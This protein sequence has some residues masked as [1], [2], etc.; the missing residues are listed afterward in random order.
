[1]VEMLGMEVDMKAGIIKA[2]RGRVEKLQA[3]LGK[4]MQTH[5]PTA[6]QLAKLSGY[7]L[8]MSLALGPISRLRTRSFYAMILS[9]DSWSSKMAWSPSAVEDLHFWFSS[10]EHCHGQPFWKKDPRVSVLSWSDASDSGWGGFSVTTKGT[11]LAKG[12]WPVEVREHGWS[13][14]WRE[15]RA[16]SLVVS[17]LS[18]ELE[19]SV[20]LHRSDNQAAVR[21]IQVGSAKPHL[22][23]VA[24][25][26]H[27]VCGEHGIRL[28]A[29]WVPRTQNELADYLSKLVDVDDWQVHPRLF[30]ELDDVWGPHTLD[31]FASLRTK[32]IE[33]F[34]S[35]WWNPGCAGI[36]AFTMDWSCERVWLVPPLYLIG[37]V[38][39]MLVISKCHGT[40]VVPEWPSA[41]W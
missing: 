36:D 5:Y 19:G 11:E 35:R 27:K 4:M 41:P 13:S 40:L 20:C 26:I 30:E 2:S 14:T 39:D 32:Q 23:Q 7:L 22:Q 28:I 24:L 37:Q 18:T 8:S 1:M 15:L 6:R 17:S 12:E 9:G 31:C 3:F 33:K 38:V 21:I 25:E 16:V 10:F 29:E 34:C